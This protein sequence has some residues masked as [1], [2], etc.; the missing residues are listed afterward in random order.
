MQL[1][2]EQKN[3]IKYKVINKRLKEFV[4][5]SPR[6]TAT[7]TQLATQANQQLAKTMTD[8]AVQKTLDE[9]DSAC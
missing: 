8:F 9:F 6:D 1:S 4:S 2:Q 7:S 5:T 3:K